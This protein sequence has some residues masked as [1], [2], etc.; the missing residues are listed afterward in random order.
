MFAIDHLAFPCFDVR[1]TLR[2]YTELLGGVLRHAQSG[3]AIEWNAKEYLLIAIDLPGGV[4]VDFFT[5]DGIRR[6]ESDGLPK[7]IRHVALAVGT[8]DE[9]M[10]FKARFEQAPVPFWTETHDVDDMHVYA[11]D[12]NGVT[13][14]ILAVQDGQQS[15]KPD[16]QAANGVVDRWFAT[17]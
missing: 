11:T 13:V 14:E 9:V 5:F 16:P 2:F 8:R 6:P 15:R 3:P 1:A 10:R 7:D 17:R 12:P 4:T